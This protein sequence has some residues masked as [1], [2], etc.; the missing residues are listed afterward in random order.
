MQPA[1][2]HVQRAWRQLASRRHALSMARLRDASVCVVCHDECTRVV[3]CVNGHAACLGCA[4]ASG[5]AS[6]C[7]VCREPRHLHVDRTLTPL[8]EASSIKLRCGT[9]NR[10]VTWRDCETHRA[11]CPAHR[12]ACPCDGCNAH[13]RACD[14]ANHVYSAHHATD[15]L[16]NLLPDTETHPTYSAILAMR[17]GQDAAMLCVGTTVVVVHLALPPMGTSEPFYVVSLR[18]Y[19]EGPQSPALHVRLRQ[20]RMENG[21]WMSEH[22]VGLIP[23]VL[24]S[25]ELTPHTASV[26]LVHA[27]VATQPW[28]DQPMVCASMSWQQ[29]RLVIGQSGVRDVLPHTAFRPLRGAPV[30]IVSLV[31]EP[32]VDVAVSA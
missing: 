7:A 16:L 13:V 28:S 24:A 19:Y 1:V 4:L 20:H 14:L 6:S 8:M 9:C 32:Q 23:P 30:V 11:W 15:L 25:R 27:C 26:P 2:V 22:H 12:F 31:F 10:M 3:R 21:M 29:S 5:A 17:P 18:A